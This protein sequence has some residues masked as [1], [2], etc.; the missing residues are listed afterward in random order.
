MN[1]RGQQRNPAICC[2]TIKTNNY[3]WKAIGLFS[4]SVLNGR[5]HI[6]ER[7]HLKSSHNFSSIVNK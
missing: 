7:R 4:D 1:D 2:Y 6:F 3:N 5:K